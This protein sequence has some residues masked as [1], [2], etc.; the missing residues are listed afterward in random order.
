M[1]HIG[2]MG[3][4]D[5]HAKGYRPHCLWVLQAPWVQLPTTALCSPAPTGH[6][7]S[8]LLFLQSLRELA[9]MRSLIYSSSRTIVNLEWKSWLPQFVVHLTVNC[10]TQLQR[11]REAE[12]R[13]IDVE[14]IRDVYRLNK[15]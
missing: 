11:H 5:Y 1:I 3:L 7:F 4:I 2:K 14:V 6:S 9:W 15:I 8:L 13:Q 10:Y 12:R